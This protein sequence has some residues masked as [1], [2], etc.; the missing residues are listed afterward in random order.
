MDGFHS[1]NNALS[2]CRRRRDTVSTINHVP[3]ETLHTNQTNWVA[4]CSSL[5]KTMMDWLHPLQMTSSWVLCEK[6]LRK[7]QTTVRWHHC[8]LKSQDSINS[9]TQVMKCLSF[10]LRKFERKPLVREHLI[11]F[12]GKIFENGHLKSAPPQRWRGISFPMYFPIFGHHHHPKKPGQIRALFDSRAQYNGVS[13][14]DM[15]L[16]W[17][18]KEPVAIT[19][20]IQQMYYCFLVREEDR[21]FLKF[22]WF[23][24]NHLKR[25]IVEYCM[26]VHVF[27]NSPSPVIA[28]YDLRKSVHQDGQD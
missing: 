18:R 23:Q 4:Q 2:S 27:G 20:D 21:N 12:I 3:A 24:D 1:L 17:F 14:N 15:L 11:S 10:L 19:A 7:M 28:I 5:Q 16:I 6:G 9:R 13:L 22:F 26:K 8:R 25:D